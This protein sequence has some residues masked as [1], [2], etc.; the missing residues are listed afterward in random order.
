M[1][2]QAGDEADRRSRCRAAGPIRAVTAVER[3][4][5]VNRG[6]RAGAFSGNVQ[7]HGHPPS[8]VGR[9][10]TDPYVIEKFGDRRRRFHPPARLDGVAVPQLRASWPAALGMRAGGRGRRCSAVLLGYDELTPLRAGAA[11]GGAVGAAVGAG[12]RSCCGGCARPAAGLLVL[13]VG[14]VLQ[15]IAVTHPPSTSDDDYRYMWD[16]KV[17][18]AG[19]DPYRYPPAAPQLARLRDAVPVRCARRTAPGRYAGRVHVDQPADGAHR[20]PAGGRGGVR[21]HAR[22]PR[23]AATA[24]TCRCSCSVRSA[25]CSIALAAA[26]PRRRPGWRRCGPGARWWSIEYAQQRAHRLAG[27][28]AVRA[29]ARGAT[30][31]LGRRRAGRRGD[32]GQDL[33]GAGAAV[34]DAPLVAGGRRGRDGWWCSSTSRTCWRWART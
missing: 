22:A 15:L 29:G 28:A 24:A 18:F 7:P 33:S 3:R 10:R 20:L 14:A 12:G 31:R 34:A 26:A 2:E 16:A 25:R 9:R 27:D 23:S 11:A 19:V 4:V 5:L 8:L 32:R 30:A 17:Q 21:R 6:Q 13:G 1:A